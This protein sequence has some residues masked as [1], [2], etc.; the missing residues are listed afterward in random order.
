MSDWLDHFAA[1]ER[2]AEPLVVVTVAR[3]EGSAPREVG[4]RILIGAERIKGTIGGGTLEYK[5]IASAREMLV[6]DSAPAWLESTPLGPAI[7]QC[8]GGNVALHFERIEP[9]A[10]PAW[11]EAL[12]AAQAAGQPAVLVSDINAPE[13]QHLVVRANSETGDAMGKAVLRQA[14][15]C[16]AGA[17]PSAQGRLLYELCG[18]HPWHI[19]LFGAGHVGRALVSVL[20]GVPSRILWIDARPEQ[21]PETIPD[22]VTKI[23]TEDGEAAVDEAPTGAYFLVMTHSHD[24]DLERVEAVLRRGDFAYLGLIGSATKRARFELRLRARGITDKQL[25][26]LTCPIGITGIAGK[27][28]AAIAISAAAE[29]LR[30]HEV[31][32]TALPAERSA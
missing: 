27:S 24:I 7:G 28:P 22:N 5:A 26:R 1:F 17:T 8:C 14:R 2:W 21:F 18:Q 31:R 32:A 19:I 9:G 29:L 25:R 4:A 20:A 12:R 30:L 13:A 6:G 3:V 11:I 23:V 15:E 10:A 16:L